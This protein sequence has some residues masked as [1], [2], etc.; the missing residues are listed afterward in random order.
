MC[1]KCMNRHLRKVLSGAN[2]LSTFVFN[3][4]KVIP[5]SR[6]LKFNIIKGLNEDPTVKYCLRLP[7]FYSGVF[8]D[9]K[10]GISSIDDSGAII[11]NEDAEGYI[12]AT[13]SSRY[14]K[15]TKS[16]NIKTQKRDD[17]EIVKEALEMLSFS[18]IRGLNDK[19]DNIKSS[20][21]LP[22]ISE[23]GARIKWYVESNE[24]RGN[25][26][27]EDG[28][29]SAQETDVETELCAE[30]SSGEEKCCKKFNLI[31][32]KRNYTDKKILIIVP[33][34]DDEM[35]FCPS[36]IRDN[37]N[38][39]NKVY[40]C[41]CCNNDDNPT[42][43]H[44][45]SQGAEYAQH[46]HYEIINALGYLGVPKENIFL[47]GYS[48]GWQN[49]HIYNSGNVVRTSKTG[50]TCT[51]STK[52]FTDYHTVKYGKPADYTGENAICDMYDIIMDI[53][54]HEIYACD[55]DFH[56]DHRAFA[57]IFDEAMGRILK[58]TDYKPDVHK[59][60]A[61]YTSGF[62]KRDFLR[63]DKL[64]PIKKPNKLHIK[65]TGDTEN[66][67]F[68]W[69]DR[70]R[71]KTIDEFREK[72][73]SKNPAIQALL[74][75]GRLYNSIEAF[76]N[77]DFVLW[78]RRTDGLSYKAKVE[79]SSGNAEYI[80][81]FKIVDCTSVSAS[82]LDFSAGIWHPTDD[83]KTVKM[84]FDKPINPVCI[85]LYQNSAKNQ[86]IEKGLL[87][88]SDGTALHINMKSDV[89]KT[90]CLENKENIKWLE[91]TVVKA[92]GDKFGISEIEVYDTP[93]TDRPVYVPNTQNK[94]INM[95][96]WVYPYNKKYRY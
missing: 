88:L 36:V 34:G 50:Y 78:K 20:L 93:D 68:L 56:A 3:S 70:V 32:R 4:I 62:S 39:D 92:F 11:A 45:N 67:M 75:Y 28:Q 9:W 76:I 86:R 61:Y 65:C 90:V 84:I 41:Y 73:Y 51:Y 87:K 21:T 24:G 2:Y 89:Y 47:L 30:I 64:L 25:V 14:L 40:I 1:Q 15:K 27:S 96:Q 69:K 19:E 23:N 10:S 35:L 74:R 7:E 5:V 63:Y 37:I 54:P 94:K 79:A 18:T 49:E 77:D 80:K 17:K 52:Y 12:T 26:I 13:V 8:I 66:P 6:K 53:H 58:N 85:K 82:A 33:H 44:D 22:L 29:I 16:F 46:R 81:D 48:T 38:K 57:L 43:R 95:E 42:D 83:K 31:V 71:V 55:M 72:D 59:G 60:F 91:F